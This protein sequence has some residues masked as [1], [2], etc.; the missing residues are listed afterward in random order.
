MIEDM[1]KLKL[2]R[3]EL[4]LVLLPFF[5]FGI[6]VLTVLDV[7]ID[8]FRSIP[9]DIAGLL[10][11]IMLYISLP[12]SLPFKQLLLGLGLWEKQSELFPTMPTLGGYLLVSFAY[13]V[14][15]L[16]ALFVIRFLKGQYQSEGKVLRS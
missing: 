11:N 14:L 9:L 6:Q 13:A 10:F 8:L 7:S 4:V 15:I 2:S 5:F 16:I 12:V 1:K 3:L